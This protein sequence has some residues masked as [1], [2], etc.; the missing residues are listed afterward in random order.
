[1]TVTIQVP[2][3]APKELSDEQFEAA[4][5]RMAQFSD[6]TPDL[7]IEAFSRESLYEGRE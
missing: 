6:K 3:P 4:L 1:L 2:L 7:P 5:D